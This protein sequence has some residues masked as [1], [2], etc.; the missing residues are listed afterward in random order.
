[1]QQL[2]QMTKSELDLNT[3][4]I[5]ITMRIQ[6]EFPEL[7]HYLNEMPITIPIVNNPEITREIL[8]NYYESLFMFIANYNAD[9]TK[10]QALKL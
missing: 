5:A 6:K 1:M 4:I 2:K 3:K 8:Q 7:S 10:K 9:L